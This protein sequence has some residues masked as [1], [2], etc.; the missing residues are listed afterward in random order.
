MVVVT[1]GNFKAVLP[2]LLQQLQTCEF[3]SFD[4]EMSGIE[5]KESRNRKDDT[6]EERY[7][8][9]IQVAKKYSIIQ[10]GMCVFHKSP[11]STEDGEVV[12]TGTPYSFYMFP[13]GG[14]RD[15]TLSASSCS[16]LRKNNMD[17]GKWIGEGVNF[18]RKDQA[19]RLRAKAEEVERS[20]EVD[21]ASN[22][23]ESKVLLLPNKPEDLAWLN[24]Q[25]E[26]L[27]KFISN[28]QE[29]RFVFGASNSYLRRCIYEYLEAIHPTLGVE[30]DASG[31]IAVV[32]LDD[33]EKERMMKD[34][35]DKL[36]DSLGFRIIFE[37]LCKVKKPLVGHNCLFDLLFMISWLED[38]LP[39]ELGEFKKQ[40]SL[41]IPV[42]FDTKFIS[43]SGS[44][45]GVYEDTVLG[46]LY[47]SV[48]LSRLVETKAKGF[49]VACSDDLTEQL[50]EAGYDAYVTGAI[51]AT[52]LFDVGLD[53]LRQSSLNKL[54]LMQSLYNISLSPSEPH[55][56][57][58]VSGVIYHLSNFD[59]DTKTDQIVAIF[60]QDKVE[61]MWIDDSS[62]FLIFQNGD[63][64]ESPA[65]KLP[66][67]W[68]LLTYE[69]FLSHKSSPI[70]AAAPA[71]FWSSFVSAVT[72]VIS[73][74]QAASVTAENA[75]LISKK[76]RLI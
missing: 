11:P 3:V 76:R 7:R 17:F 23:G 12:M 37:E 69:K 59:A 9:M 66:E 56:N 40:F 67:G 52:F 5:T 50:H 13:D 47:K 55:G 1:R 20:L 61:V 41:L 54:Y 74:P 73:S 53:S 21:S 2:E 44:G 35:K 33:V 42:L 68:R 31:C 60:P 22:Q 39:L 14:G 64:R 30:K 62:V 72:S 16:F 19:G 63:I 18:V 6:P 29:T 24:N 28:H 49:L 51:F 38:D 71:S 36:T 48:V 10:F 27:G 75:V 45:G 15:I 25:K 34:R 4:E 43:T 65:T 32:K 46:D 57:F 8:K 70:T 58:R 26:L